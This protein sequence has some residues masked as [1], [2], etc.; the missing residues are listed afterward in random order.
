MINKIIN[1]ILSF[2]DDM[3]KNNYLI[4]TLIGLFVL[5]IWLIFFR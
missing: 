3:D 4:Y 1:S 2:G 5:I